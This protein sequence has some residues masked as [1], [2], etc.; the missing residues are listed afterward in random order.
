[1]KIYQM[2]LPI[3]LKHTLEDPQLY[4][5]H[6]VSPVSLYLWFSYYMACSRP[7]VWVNE[8]K[9]LMFAPSFSYLHLH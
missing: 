1:M 8:Q 7:S 9:K 4:S 2:I 5:K 6:T 3:K